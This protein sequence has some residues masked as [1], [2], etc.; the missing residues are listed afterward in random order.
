ME[1]S[2]SD[3]FSEAA[4]GAEGRPATH[5]GEFREAV[6]AFPG[7]FCRWETS[8]YSTCKPSLLVSGRNEDL[9]VCIKIDRYSWPL[10]VRDGG[11]HSKQGH[12][13]SV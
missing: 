13:M 2:T 9:L 5:T 12:F 10:E 7:S 3:E 1:R 11:A 4:G 6:K 8:R